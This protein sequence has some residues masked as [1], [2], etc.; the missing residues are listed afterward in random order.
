MGG[1]TKL[2]RN[3]VLIAGPTASGKSS[4]AFRLA[5]VENGLIVNADSMQVYDVLRVLTARPS[6]DEIE[7]VPHQLYGHVSPAETYS[8][9]MWLRDVERLSQNG[10]FEDRMP[11]FVGGTGL[12]FRALLQGLAVLPDIPSEIREHLRQELLDGGA[13]PLHRR[14]AELD[15]EG[16]ASLRAADGHRIVRALEVLEAT[17]KPLRYWQGQ[18]VSGVVDQT[19]VRCL[20]IEPERAVLHAR[21]NER[22]DRMMDEGAREEVRAIQ[23]MSLSSKLPVMKAIGLRE[24]IAVEQGRLELSTAVEQAKAATRQYAK[25]QSTW[26]RTQF[27]DQWQRV[28][29]F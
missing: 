6:L 12:Y 29:A 8:V 20:V 22:F 2:I 26:F 3:A 11:I 17:G 28:Q 7:R 13:L 23:A 14:L 16:A 9:G 25:R 1:T 21:I 5:E 15:A 18:P 19:S 10:A 4:A 27:G 24:L